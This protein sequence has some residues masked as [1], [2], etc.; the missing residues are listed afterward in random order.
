MVF[1]SVA[2]GIVV[3]GVL[4]TLWVSLTHIAG[5]FKIYA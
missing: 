4:R 5:K 3:N 2:V 1:H